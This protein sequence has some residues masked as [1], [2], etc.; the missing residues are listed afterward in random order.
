MLVLGVL[1]MYDNFLNSYAFEQMAREYN[2]RYN[3]ATLFCTNQKDEEIKLKVKNDFEKFSHLFYMLKN[4]FKQSLYKFDDV[5]K[6]FKEW[7]KEVSEFLNIDNIKTNKS[8]PNHIT[9]KLCALELMDIIQS[10]VSTVGNFV[11]DNAIDKNNDIANTQSFEK[12][13]HDDSNGFI[14]ASCKLYLK[15]I[16]IVKMFYERI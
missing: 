5:F 13:Q 1:N 11:C 15:A 2:A 14:K 10:F 16:N 8:L 3:K 6:N 9:H 12:R 4:A 7:Q